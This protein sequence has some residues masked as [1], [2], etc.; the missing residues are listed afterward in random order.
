MFNMKRIGVFILVLIIALTVIACNSDSSSDDEVVAKIDDTRVTKS[1]LYD[2]LVRQNGAQ[3]LNLLISNKIVEAEIMEQEIEI[4]DEDI[5]KEINIMKDY[6][7]S[8][9]AFNTDLAKNGLTLDDVKDNIERNRQIELLLDPYIDITEEEMKEYFETNKAN[10]AQ[11]E[12]VKASHILVETEEE[13]LD[14]IDK[15]DGGEDFAELAKEY[16]TDESNSA[17]GGNLGYFNRAGMLKEFSDAAFALKVG[18]ISEPVKTMYGYH[19]IKLEDK[20]EAKDAVY[21]DSIEVIKDALFE[22][23]ASD[24]YMKWYAEMLEK[25]EITTYLD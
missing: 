11:E 1:E 16:S 18:D 21:D 15:L 9:D 8:E 22:D 14:I 10:F 5:E 20:L 24:G 12:Q 3:V 6:Y 19:I 4:P 23:K 17:S 2:E 7:G 13:A 25:Y